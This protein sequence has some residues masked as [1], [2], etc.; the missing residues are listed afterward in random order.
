MAVL[1]TERLRLR[2]LTE[3][4]AAFVLELVNEPDWLRFIGDKNVRSLEDAR[5]YLR[6][7]PM[8]SYRKHG[9]GLL[10][11]ETKATEGA[12]GEATGIC[13]LLRRPEL[14]DVEVGFAFLHRFRGKGYARESAAAVVDLAR[15]ELG[16]D[17]LVAITDPENERSIRVLEHVGFVFERRWRKSA[18][19]TELSLYGIPPATA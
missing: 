17:R 14:G 10:A 2:E 12:T 18:E 16:I 19:E 3:A 5:R 8:A 4:D 11:V 1:E 6:D 7:G 13:G 9:F 15:R